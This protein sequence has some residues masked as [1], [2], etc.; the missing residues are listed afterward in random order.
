MNPAGETPACGFSILGFS[1]LTV[2]AEGPLRKMAELG[3]RSRTNYQFSKIATLN[4]ESGSSSECKD[5]QPTA[6]KG[7]LSSLHQVCK[8][9]V[10]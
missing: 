2:F 4:S 5:V 7:F 3:G 9:K 1:G 10:L 6:S 8:S